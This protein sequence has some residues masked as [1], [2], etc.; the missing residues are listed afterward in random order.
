MDKKKSFSWSRLPPAY[1]KSVYWALAAFTMLVLFC[2]IFVFFLSEATIKDWHERIPSGSAV[3]VTE[4]VLNKSNFTP[5]PGSQ[6]GPPLTNTNT[7]KDL[8]LSIIISDMGLNDITLDQVMKEFPNT[9]TLA[10]SPYASDLERKT[11]DAS[12]E[13]F[14]VLML[15]PMEPAN[16]PKDDPGPR[17][18]STRAKDT[19]N[20]FNLKW[21]VERATD[22]SGV[23]N[24]MGSKFLTD[25]AR[26]ARVL[27]FL[28]EKKIY[29]VENI[30]TAGSQAAAAARD[31]LVP[32]AAVSV[33]L[34]EIPT[35]SYI[36][37]QLAQFQKI[38]AEQG[39]AIA[40]A[41][42]YPV[43]VNILKNWINDMTEKGAVFVPPGKLAR[44]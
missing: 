11:K 9:V 20:A 28:K 22:S 29:F 6:P 16:F 2:A 35:E 5:G 42:P 44:E 34:D 32:Y 27:S 25:R 24:S 30:Q 4:E 23:M 13:G 10:F 21:M 40:I 26:M 31:N 19:E 14:Q 38:A 43:T 17:A 39:G 12:D 3:I 18:L 33:T 41:R 7:V 37:Q 15:L 1:K 36:R 8:N